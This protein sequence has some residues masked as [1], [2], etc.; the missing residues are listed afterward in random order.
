MIERYVQVEVGFP[1]SKLVDRARTVLDV[2]RPRA[3][4]HLTLL[5]LAVMETG[6]SGRLDDRSDLWIEDAAEWR[7]E[8]GKFARFVREHHLTDG[9][10]TDWTAKYATVDEARQRNTTRMRRTRTAHRARTD[11]AQSAHVRDT[12]L[13]LSTLSS[14][15]GANQ[16]EMLVGRETPG[17]DEFGPDTEFVVGLLRSSEK[18]HAVLATLRMMVQEG[19]P[20]ALIGQCVREVASNGE[21]F[22]VQRF[23]GYVRSKSAPPE[24]TPATLAPYGAD[25]ALRSV[26]DW[27]KA[28]GGYRQITATD[29]REYVTPEV[30]Q[31]LGACGGL[32]AFEVADEI[33]LRMLTKKFHAEYGRA[34]HATGN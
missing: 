9:V 33:G 34:S 24:N 11:D 30:R 19:T 32:K 7:G 23:R 15:N 20:A 17:S 5:W 22:N 25:L 28:R 21:R 29:Y 16:T 13:L 6:C 31:A 8:P 2:C 14:S 18:P 10:I 3:I 4:G 27:A 26:L 1:R 12:P